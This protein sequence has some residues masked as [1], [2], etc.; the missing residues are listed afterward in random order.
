MSLVHSSEKKH[1]PSQMMKKCTFFSKI[2]LLLYF[3]HRD[4]TL[5]FMDFRC[6]FNAASVFFSSLLNF[7]L[8]CVYVGNW[9]ARALATLLW[10]F[11]CRF[12]HFAIK[13]HYLSMYKLSKKMVFKWSLCLYF[14][15]SIYVLN[16]CAI[17]HRNEK[18]MYVLASLQWFRRFLFRKPKFPNKKYLV[19]L[20]MHV[21]FF[22]IQS[23]YFV[24]L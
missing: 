5:R 22:F 15:I 4:D 18:K 20:P 19:F 11:M 24:A 9:L 23:L 21:D 16:E 8:S 14:S 13:I 10:I 2:V 3:S 12:Y 1:K 7:I 17:D 6:S